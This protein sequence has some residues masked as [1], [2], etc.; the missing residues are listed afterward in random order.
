M[1]CSRWERWRKARDD[2]RVSFGHNT[3]QLQGDTHLGDGQ[4]VNVPDFYEC[5]ATSYPAPGI[6]QHVT[7]MY[8][9]PFLC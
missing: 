8:L 9:H 6:H 3:M 5:C 2:V 1:R 4:L 7:C